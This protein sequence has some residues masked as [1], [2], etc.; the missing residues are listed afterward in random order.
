MKKID[1]IL[2]DNLKNN[3]QRIEDDNFTERIV[4]KHLSKGKRTA[5]RPFLNFASFIIGISAVLLS[6]GLV[7]LF[8]TENIVIDYI[9]FKEQHGMILILISL[10]FL[11]YKWIEELTTSAIK[12][13]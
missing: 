2:K 11:I 6:I 9:I 13:K 12:Y 4:E 1:S 5:N 10:L 3:I 7:I 8:K